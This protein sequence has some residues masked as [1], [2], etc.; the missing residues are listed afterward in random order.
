MLE[1]I[2]FDLDNTLIDWSDCNLFGG[3]DEFREPYLN[4]FYSYLCG[5]GTPTVDLDKFKK[6]FS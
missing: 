1:A 3:W 6:L 2:L 5:L 4:K